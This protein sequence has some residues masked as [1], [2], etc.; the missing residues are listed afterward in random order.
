MT[1]SLQSLLELAI[2]AI[3]KLSPDEK[4]EFRQAWQAQCDRTSVRLTGA[5]VR[6]LRQIKVDPS[7]D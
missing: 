5:D 7:G 4:R 3:H 6:W 1:T 2:V